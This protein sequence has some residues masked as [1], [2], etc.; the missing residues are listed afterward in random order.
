VHHLEVVIHKFIR[1]PYIH[2][3]KYF[4][5]CLLIISLKLGPPPR[6]P[7]PSGPPGAGPPGGQHT[8]NIIKS[9]DLLINYLFL[10]E[11][12]STATRPSSCPS[13]IWPSAWSTTSR[14]SYRHS[15][16]VSTITRL[17]LHV[18]NDDVTFLLS[19]KY[20]D[21]RC[22]SRSSATRCSWS[23]WTPWSTQRFVLVVSV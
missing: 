12:R 4:I 10:N 13:T 6:G 17:Y 21:I 14:Y 19:I 18:I 7:P 22:S 15:L 20:L 9:Y 5:R 2:F 23:R 3:L 1:D 16:S 11:S 8:I